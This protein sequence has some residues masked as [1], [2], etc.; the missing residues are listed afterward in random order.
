M[1][2]RVG[3]HGGEREEERDGTRKRRVRKGRG[4]AIAAE[5]EGSE[6]GGKARECE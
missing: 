6:R 3:R 2:G 5:G 4:G 1:V